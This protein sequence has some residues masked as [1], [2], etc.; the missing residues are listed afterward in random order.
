MG[1]HWGYVNLLTKKLCYNPIKKNRRRI[2]LGIRFLGQIS[3]IPKHELRGFW[4]YSLT[5]HHRDQPA[6]WSL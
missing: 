2:V 3:I 5:F 6:G 4:G 1:F